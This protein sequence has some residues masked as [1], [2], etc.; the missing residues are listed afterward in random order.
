MGYRT[1]LEERSASQTATL[2]GISAEQ[3]RDVLDH[4]DL[5]V[6]PFWEGRRPTP[7]EQEEDR[8]CLE[9]LGSMSAAA[10]FE[11]LKIR[12]REAPPGG[13]ARSLI[14]RRLFEKFRECTVRA[15]FEL[16]TRSGG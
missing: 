15:T 10:S 6:G 16:C 9:R 2:L 12:Y 14:V 3:V 1:P 7:N 5:G 13:Q 11:A 4:T 8:N